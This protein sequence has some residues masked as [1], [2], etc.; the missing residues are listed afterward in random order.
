M[1]LEAHLPRDQAAIL[2]PWLER[3]RGEDGYLDPLMAA[4]GMDQGE[5]RAALPRVKGRLRDNLRRRPEVEQI[6]RRFRR[7]WNEVDEA[8][9]G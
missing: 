5:A 6:A 8:G 3:K 4:T 1:R 7:L 2:R 9:L